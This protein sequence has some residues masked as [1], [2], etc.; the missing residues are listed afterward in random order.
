MLSLSLTFLYKKMEC[1][2]W[3]YET[4]AK[5]SRSVTV[6]KRE[7]SL[8]LESSDDDPIVKGYKR[9]GIVVLIVTKFIRPVYLQI[10]SSN[11]S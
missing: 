10:E 11:Y 7:E 5:L 4:N 8:E 1:L 9:V 2:S 3:K 6:A